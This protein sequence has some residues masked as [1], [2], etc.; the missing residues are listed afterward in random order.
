MAQPDG[1]TTLATTYRQLAGE[2][3]RRLVWSAA[4]VCVSVAAMAVAACVI[5]A[6]VQVHL[7][8]M[9]WVAHNTN[10]TGA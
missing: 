8:N 1:V 5:S 2:L 4:A 10:G 7:T 3:L 6:S 9:L